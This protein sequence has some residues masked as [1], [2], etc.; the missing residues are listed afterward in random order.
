MKDL[1]K[2]KQERLKEYEKSPY[3]YCD[4]DCNDAWGH[5][6]ACFNRQGFIQETIDLC[7]AQMEKEY[8]RGYNDA[9]EACDNPLGV[10][11]HVGKE[12]NEK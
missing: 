10:K 6:R 1:E 3:P 7:F 9:I 2:F 5:S 11:S 12:T 4:S 8:M